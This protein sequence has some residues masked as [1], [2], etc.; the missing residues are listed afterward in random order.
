MA[1]NENSGKK[2]K[3]DKIANVQTILDSS[4]IEAAAI[5]DRHIHR[6][7][8]AKTIKT[9]LQRACEYVIDHAIG[10]AR[11]KIEHS[12][13]ILTYSELAKSAEVIEK[14]PPSILADVE[15]IAQKYQEN[16]P[17]TPGQS[18]G[19]TESGQPEV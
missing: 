1:G 19:V 4:A 16:T 13:G 11:Q 8:G 5:L 17:S 18:P 3:Y 6:M 15:E 2:S 12:G 10:K 14:K 9:S 7:K